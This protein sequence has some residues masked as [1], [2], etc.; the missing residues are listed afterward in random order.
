MAQN[1][2]QPRDGHGDDGTGTQHG[3]VAA[4]IAHRGSHRFTERRLPDLI[5]RGTLMLEFSLMRGETMPLSLVHLA[6]GAP[7]TDFLSLQFDREGRIVLTHRRGEA[8]H[9]IS[10]DASRER[11]AGGLM[12]LSWRWDGPARESL[13]TLKSLGP[14]TIR[15][16]AGTAPLPLTRG[17][18]SAIAQGTG[19]AKIGPRVD[20]IALGDHLQP[21]GPA[22]CFA[23]STPILT[24]DGPRPAAHLRTGDL[25]ET[26]DAGPQE[27]VWAGRVSLPA[28]GYLR[29]VKLCAPVFSE[30]RDLWVM[31][32]HRVALS[33]PSV[34]YIFGE[35][36][37]L[38]EAGDLVDGVAA[39][40]PDRPGVLSWYGLLLDDHHLLIADGCKLESLHIGRLARNPLLGA[41]TALAELA[42]DGRLPLHRK[43]CR[44]IV[45][46]IEARTLAEARRAGLK[47]FVA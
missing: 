42:R 13:L 34:D 43:A 11:L 10:I 17:E 45:R 33:G 31:P 23:P 41:T 9:A 22:G 3:W 39:L 14:G 46:G 36:E 18:F 19:P 16:Q 28:L 2:T 47:P 6:Q 21:L 30:N 40:Q 1:T 44:K 26:A 4:H 12:R 32:Q 8:V 25:V 15:Q 38:I 7:R 24:P 20:W 5:A 35:E 29:P 27:L 37:V